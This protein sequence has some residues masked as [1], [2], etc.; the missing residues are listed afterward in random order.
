MKKNISFK[1]ALSLVLKEINVLDTERLYCLFALRRV[2]AEDAIA[3]EP[4]PF[5]DISSRDG[6][7]LRSE[8]A[9]KASPGDPVRLKISGTIYAGDK[10]RYVCTKAAV[11]SIMTGAPLPEAADAVVPLE[12]VEYS[13][14]AIKLNKPVGKG[15]Y[16]R[17][18]G[19]EARAGKIIIKK[20]KTIRPIEVG[21][22]AALGYKQVKVFKNPAVNI[23]STGNELVDAGEKVDKYSV[24]D[25]NSYSLAAQA[26][27]CGARPSLLGI[28]SDDPG[29]TIRA[30]RK[31]LKGDVL[32]LSGGVSRGKKDIILKMLLR[33]RADIKFWWVK[34]KPG[35]PFAFALLKQKPIFCVPGTPATSFVV[36][37]KFIRPAILKMMGYKNPARHKIM[38]EVAEKIS[39]DK[40]RRHFL[41]V[42]IAGQGSKIRAY[43][44][45]RQVPVLLKS[46]AACDGLLTV[47][48]DRGKI[49]A[50]EKYPVEI[51]D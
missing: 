38:A 16:I 34:I 1:K 33:M 10:S 18:K 14:G 45:G 8:D 13:N 30:I 9:K 42:K 47:P 31:G 23:L 36:F 35:R 15:Q 21:M 6:F 26:L 17:K 24:R 49:S 32:I 37:E 46:L 41:R 11:F 50:G 5:C 51:L 39:V 3:N 25:S 43:L 7:A 40:G 29:R 4:I 19:S 44:S 20:G 12:D 22:L 48:E 2:L 28:T 27:E